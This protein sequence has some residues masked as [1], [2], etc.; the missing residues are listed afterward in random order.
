MATPQDAALLRRLSQINHILLVLS[1]KGGVG[2]S[3]V[4]VQLALSLLADDPT[5][6]IGLL[7][8]DLT[9]PSLPRMLGIEGRDVLASRDGWVPVY[10]D[11]D[12]VAQAAAPT[13]TPTRQAGQAV[14][15][16]GSTRENGKTAQ[17]GVLA[18]M[19]IGFLLTDSRESVV[20][21]GPKK[22]AM[23]KQFL[24]EVRWGELDYLIVDTP[25]GTS[26]EHISLVE[27]LRPLLM[28]PSPS[29][30]ALPL[31]TLS[32]VLVSTPQAV[33]LLDVS[34]ELS[35][36][37]RTELPLLGLVENMSGYVCPHCGDVVNVFGRGGAEDFCKKEESKVARG[38]TVGCKFLG[39]IPIDPELVGLLDDVAVKGVQEAKGEGHSGAEG[40]SEGAEAARLNLVQRY[41][42]IP[43]FKIVK[44]IAQKVRV[45]VEEQ[46]AK[47][48]GEGRKLVS[49]ARRGGMQ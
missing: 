27:T 26:D 31:P 39:R 2:K 23:I 47:E 48:E 4:S 41:T 38:E 22:N 11:A 7:D 33:A 29:P 8:V 18:C 16:D 28:P 6:R 42:G 1:G 32:S 24:G 13:S 43:S 5:L 12:S 3:S 20:W 15:R 30:S 25:P 36:I 44:G 40:A 49:A 21:R 34:K 37:R 17:G 9:G 46:A 35:F 10:L 19:S 45:S 14:S